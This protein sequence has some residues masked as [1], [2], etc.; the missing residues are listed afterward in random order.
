MVK[1]C[2]LSLFTFGVLLN[3]GS[4][5]VDLSDRFM[6]LLNQTN[7]EF[8]E[9]LEAKYRDVPLFKNPYQNYDFAIRSRKEKLEIR[10]LVEPFEPNNPTFFTPHI[11]GLRMV[12][13]LATNSE[14]ALITGHDVDTAL[15]QSEFNADWGKV[16]FFQPK[17]GFSSYEHCKMLALYKEDVG[18]VYVFFLFRQARRELDNRFVAVRFQENPETH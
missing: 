11:R 18:M 8:L 12:T 14:D 13:H 15:L 10:Y 16:F 5:Q 6:H 17:D 1:Q 4:A 7:L 2:L 3:C 9:P